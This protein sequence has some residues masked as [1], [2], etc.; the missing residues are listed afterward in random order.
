MFSHIFVSVTDFQR[1]L[2]FH[3]AV[4]ASLGLEQRFCDTSKPWAGWHSAGKSR[5]FFVI[6]H[7]F[8]GHPHQPGNGQ[9]VAFAASTRAAVE[10]THATAL[11]HGGT[12][13]GPP[14][15][16]PQYHANYYGAY[17]RDPDHNKFC[18]VCHAPEVA[19]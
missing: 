16:R 14:G 12:C 1:A 2:R 5:P 15:L 8:D 4:M 7:P 19:A 17:F 3:S 9:M 6:C 18:V 11:Q 10:Q 13:E